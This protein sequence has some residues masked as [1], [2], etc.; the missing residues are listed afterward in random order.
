MHTKIITT[1]AD[2]AEF[3]ASFG[4]EQFI[5][6][7]TEFIRERTYFPQLCLMQVGTSKQAVAIDPIAAPE[8]DLTPLY[9][10]FANENLVKVFHAAKQDIE[11]FVHD[12]GR[13]PFPLY[14]TQIAAMVCGYGESISYENLV[15]DLVGASLDKASRF[16]DWARRPLSDR[17][18][19]YALDDVIHLR[20]IYEKLQQK[21]I[22][23]GRT[24]WIE[25]E[26][27]ALA[28]ITQ[29]RVDGARAWMRLK[30]KTRSPLMLQ[31]LRAAA[32]WREAMAAKRNVPRG[33]I[34]KDEWVV[35][36]ATQMPQ[37]VEDLLEVRG[38]NGQL[39]KD[40]MASLVDAMNE[41]RLAPKESFPV[42]IEREKPMPAAQEACLDQLKLLLRQRCDDA[43]VV[44]RLVAGK[45]ELE[46]LVRGK[47]TLAESTMGHG[48]RYALFGQAAEGLFAGKLSA[49]VMQHRGGYGLVW[50]DDNAASAISATGT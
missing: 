29:Y 20:V 43:G 25:Q 33:R 15:R 40:M 13:V 17:Q 44:P 37:S 39:S 14:D 42:A 8:M 2:L 4:D 30:I 48:W 28:D 50:S 49:R 26:M 7:D 27:L 31:L 47:I 46:A 18:L 3:C 19:V 23:A 5:T 12:S 41:A 38:L 24:S 35:Q 32:S 6:V 11:I 22:A 10:A 1:S 21:I 45:D 9:E 34:L 36:I 16:T